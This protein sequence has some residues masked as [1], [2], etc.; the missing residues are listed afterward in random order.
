MGGTM[1]RCL[2]DASRQVIAKMFDDAALA[3]L[4]LTDVVDSLGSCSTRNSRNGRT[5]T[6]TTGPTAGS[7]AK[8]PTKDCY[9]RPKPNLSPAT[10]S[11]TASADRRRES[12]YSRVAR[13]PEPDH[14]MGRTGVLRDLG[15]QCW[16]RSAADGT[17][18][19]RPG[20]LPLTLASI[21]SITQ[22][23]CN[24]AFFRDLK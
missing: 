14:Q 6:T 15:R 24:A 10:V 16:K 2:V 13:R 12:A 20:D 22:R 8:P 21:A 18:P 19:T 7:A 11:H 9:K 17:R 23:P 1:Y 3:A 5:T 4:K